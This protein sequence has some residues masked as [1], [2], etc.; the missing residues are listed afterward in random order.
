MRGVL[1]PQIERAL[2][3]ESVPAPRLKPQAISSK[4]LFLCLVSQRP[5]GFIYW[6][7]GKKKRV[8]T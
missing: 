4:Y 5:A 6:A 1:H 2:G 7:F 8:L 3:I